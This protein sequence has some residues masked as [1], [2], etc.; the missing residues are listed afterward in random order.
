MSLHLNRVRAPVSVLSRVIGP[1]RIASLFRGEDK[2]SHATENTNENSLERLS[3]TE[4][5]LL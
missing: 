3:P 1:I 2:Q 5:E 4:R